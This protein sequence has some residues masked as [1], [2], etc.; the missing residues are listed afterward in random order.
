MAG[1]FR[2]IL[3]VPVAICGLVC[4]AAPAADAA[5]FTCS[6]NDATT[7][8]TTGDLANTA[9]STSTQLRSMAAAP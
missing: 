8:W 3:R 4:I 2:G 9:R 5:N 1:L 6:W 7:N